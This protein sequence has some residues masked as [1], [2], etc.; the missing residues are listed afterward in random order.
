MP[1]PVKHLI[2]DRPDPVIV[3]PED[4]IPRALSLMARHD[5]SQLPVV[6]PDH[7]PVGMVNYEGILRGVRNFRVRLED[8]HVRDVMVSAPIFNVED[9]LFELLEQLKQKN[10]VLIIDPGGQLNG[11]VTSYDSTE[12]FRDRAEN[13]MLVEDIEM[14]VR[15]FI[16]LAYTEP[17]GSIHPERLA[18]A[19]ARVSGNEGP[20]SHKEKS[21]DSLSLG[22]YVLM[23]TFKHTWSFF[24]PIFKV[25]RES[26]CQLLEDVRKTRNGLAHFHNEITL[27]Q[28]DQLRFCADWLARCQ[29]EYQHARTEELFASLVEASKLDANSPIALAAEA[30]ITGLPASGNPALLQP[31]PK[32]D[33]RVVAEEAQPAQSRYSPLADWLSGQPGKVDQVKLSFDQIEVII[34][35]SLPPSAYTHRAWW[36]NVVL[37][38]PQS[39]VWLEAGWRTTYIN[40]SEKH[41]T[42][43]RIR[44]REQA[45]I[46]FFNQ[47]ISKLKE[48]TDFPIRELSPDGTNWIVCQSLFSARGVIGEF[49]FSFARG[50]RFRVDLYLDTGEQI[51]TKQIFDRIHTHKLDLEKELGNLAWERIDEKR[52]SRIALYHPGDITSSENELNT[53]RDWAA[54]TM[55]AFYKAIEPVAAQAGREILQP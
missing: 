47:L 27:E 23:L 3:F 38:H 13:M 11:I 41:V 32:E 8:L 24:E 2:Q 21:F 25:P 9:D 29:E 55:I 5:F 31:E 44:E 22:Q 50:K 26:L 17:D 7:E 40:L 46:H 48:K 34:G 12:Y 30:V 51:T 45:Y 37:T 19:M 52:A 14:M 10:C 39:Q 36:A 54:D 1:Y 20:D 16:R 53:L 28:T 43:A 42:F 15:D 35:G 33:R 49:A 4:S 6:N 18:E